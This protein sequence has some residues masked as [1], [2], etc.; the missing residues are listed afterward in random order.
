MRKEDIAVGK[1][2]VNN[3]ESVLREVVEETDARH[4]K[5]NQ[6]Q[7]ATGKLIPAPNQISHRRQFAR[8]ANRE[9]TE[10]ETARTHPYTAEAWLDAESLVPRG[11]APLDRVKAAIS[12]ATEQLL[13][14]RGK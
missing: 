13:V 7:L 2:Y 1:S 3:K 4:V 9:A 11:G 5:F 12:G 6:F 10:A 8:W 14:P